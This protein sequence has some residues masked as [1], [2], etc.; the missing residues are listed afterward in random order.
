MAFENLLDHAVVSR[1]AILRKG[2]T[3]A[4]EPMALLKRLATPPSA[5]HARPPV[6][7]NSVPKSGTH[8][9]LQIT[10][11]LPCSRYLGR[12]IATCP[13]LTLRERSPVALSRRIAKVLPGETLGAHLYYSAEV[14]EAMSRLGALH[15]FIYRDPRDV[16]TSETFYLA[17][18]N[19]WHRMHKYFKKLPD[20]AA[21]LALSLDGLDERYPEAN[22]RL[23]PYAGWIRA[24]GVVPIRYE[25]LTGECQAKEIERIVEAWRVQG[26]RTDSIDDLV[27]RLIAAIDPERSHTFREGGTGKWRRR[28][29]E[30]E[31]EALTSR[32][33]PSL[34]AF[35]YAK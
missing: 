9:L 32:L 28:L 10:R 31:A 8:L 6:F 27:A 13:S 34:E 17:Q 30:S 1:S 11:A 20:N 5:Y 33:R 2:L 19:R 3:F 21:R 14:A 23:L 26:G 4:Q 15:L 25:D 35:G 29:T 22:A 18:M 7:A 16:I 12:F 24:P